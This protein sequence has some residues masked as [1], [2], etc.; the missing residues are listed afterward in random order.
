LIF[1]KEQCEKEQNPLMGA[2]W[3]S[4]QA[5]LEFVRE[6]PTVEPVKR[7]KWINTYGDT[8]HDIRDKNNW[9]H[10]SECKYPA[11]TLFKSPHCPNCGAK[12]E[13]DNE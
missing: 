13:S 10:C 2:M 7:G 9:W 5:V 8:P 12:M 1:L 3:G 11:T 6:Q 4:F